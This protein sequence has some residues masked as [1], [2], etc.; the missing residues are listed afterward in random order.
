MFSSKAPPD[1]GGGLRVHSHAAY[2][3]NLRAG[4][5]RTAMDRQPCLD[6]SG[7]KASGKKQAEGGNV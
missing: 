6:F 4:N 3:R 2:N 1:R 5:G 7:G